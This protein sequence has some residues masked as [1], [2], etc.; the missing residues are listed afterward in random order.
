MPTLAE[1]CNAEAAKLRGETPP[2]PKASREA[3]KAR[4]DEDILRAA[5]VAL[6]AATASADPTKIRVALDAMARARE[7]T[8]MAAPTAGNVTIVLEGLDADDSDA[9]A[10]EPA[11]THPLQ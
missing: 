9:A 5:E 1:R 11:A 10:D 2:E 4:Q 7:L 6:A 8:G 3:R